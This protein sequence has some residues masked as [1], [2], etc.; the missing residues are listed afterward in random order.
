[1]LIGIEWGNC[2]LPMEILQFNKSYVTFRRQ[3]ILFFNYI[4]YILSNCYNTSKMKLT[5][6]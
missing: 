1:M 4:K 5:A 6:Q 3:L 2:I